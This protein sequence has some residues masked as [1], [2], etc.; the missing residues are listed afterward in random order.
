[1]SDM[2]RG[3]MTNVHVQ[4]K[5]QKQTAIS[6]MQNKGDLINSILPSCRTSSKMGQGAFIG[7]RGSVVVRTWKMEI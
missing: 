2:E 1:M 4:Y 3:G 7:M 6:T 5:M